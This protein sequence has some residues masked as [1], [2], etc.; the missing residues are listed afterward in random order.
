VVVAGE[1][2]IEDGR[3]TLVDEQRLWHEANEIVQTSCA[4][5]AEREAYMVERLPFLESMLSAVEDAEGGPV[6]PVVPGR[7]LPPK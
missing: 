1:V 5:L 7:P 3:S 4:Y 6:A 2:V